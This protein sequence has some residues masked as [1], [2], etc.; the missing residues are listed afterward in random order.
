MSKQ[1]LHHEIEQRLTWFQWSSRRP[2]STKFNP[3]VIF[4]VFFYHD[5]CQ[6]NFNISGPILKI[7]MPILCM[8]SLVTLG[9]FSL[10]TLVKSSGTVELL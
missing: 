8:C 4:D 7:A 6:H 3:V 10:V 1:H 5:S 2:A 9:Y